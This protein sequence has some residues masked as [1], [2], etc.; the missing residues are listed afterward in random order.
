MMGE[1][2][3]ILKKLVCVGMFALAVA[4]GVREA[5]GYTVTQLTFEPSYEGEPAW[6]PDGSKISFVSDRDGNYEIY[7][8]DANGSNQKRLTYNIYSDRTPA[9]SPY[10][11]IIAFTSSR[12]GT[13]EIYLMESNGSNQRR[14]TDSY[15]I[16][17]RPWFGL[18][19]STSPAWSP[20]ESK[21]AFEVGLIWDNGSVYSDIYMLDMYDNT[22]GKITNDVPNPEM[23]IPSFNT[24]QSPSWLP[25]G[26]KIA[27]I[28]HKFQRGI[29]VKNVE[30]TDP[31]DRGYLVLHENPCW[32]YHVEWSPMGNNFA[33]SMACNSIGTSVY[34]I[35]VDRQTGIPT[36][37]P[38][39]LTYGID[40]S[41]SPD[42]TKIAYH[43][44]GDIWVMSG[45]PALAADLYPDGIVN[46]L[47]FSVFA[48]CWRQDEP[49]ADF[50]P[51]GG[52]DIVD[53]L[54]LAK[55]A[56]EWLETEEWYQP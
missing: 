16:L 37:E 39:W 46:L 35:P 10:G 6:S 41:W 28:I 43:W 11:N 22:V 25:D 53:F 27:Y 32:V 20:D 19:Y 7:V 54:D 24:D 38:I 31:N 4:G 1:T 36:R 9:W 26:D 50:A 18:T 23:I 5:K 47:D 12:D 48:D 44:R 33:F 21:I 55:L 3:K 29:K 56:E 42:G 15:E 8:M 40:P 52:D 30:A 14:V 13:S 2:N 49:L 51:D 34:I 45:F 17:D